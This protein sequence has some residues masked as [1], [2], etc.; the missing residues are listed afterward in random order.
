LADGSTWDIIRVFLASPGDLLRE[1]QEAKQV[2]ARLNAA[3]AEAGRFHCH[4][5]YWERMGPSSER[6]QEAINPAVDRCD[7]F[8]GL[9]GERWGHPTPEYT[10][11][12]EEEYRRASKRRDETGSPEIWLY[13]KQLGKGRVSDPGEDLRRVLAFRQEVEQKHLYAEFRSAREF[14]D[15]LYDRLLTYL[16][17]RMAVRLEE[18][19]AETAT[20][21]PAPGHPEAPHGATG[22]EYP[23]QIMQLGEAVARWTQTDGPGDEDADEVSRLFLLSAGWFYGQRLA[24]VLGV[25]EANAFYEMRRD[26]ELTQ[27]EHTLLVRSLV[28]DEYGRIPGYYWVGDQSDE[29]FFD[30]LISFVD[31]DPVYGVRA[32]A[33]RLLSQAGHWPAASD[34][35][36]AA[37]RDGSARVRL[38]LAR[39]LGGT[40]QDDAL[41]LTEALLEDSNDQVREA[42][43]WARLQLLSRNDPETAVEEAVRL[44]VSDLGRAPAQVTDGIA[45]ARP[46][47][48]WKLLSSTHAGVRRFAADALAQHHE[49]SEAEAVFLSRDAD[50]WVAAHGLL[51]L[52]RDEARVSP[53]EYTGFLAKCD[54]W[55]RD[56]PRGLHGAPDDQVRLARAR[57]LSP[58][59]L[60]A[61]MDFH[62]VDGPYM[63]RALAVDHFDLISDR[64]R[65][66][67]AERFE[68]IQREAQQRIEEQVGSEAARTIEASW[69]RLVPFLQARFAAAALA[70][71]A[72]HGRNGDEQ[73]AREWLAAHEGWRYQDLVAG[74]VAVLQRF[75]D[76]TDADLLVSVAEAEYGDLQASAASA[77]VSLAPGA[78]GAAAKLLLSQ[79]L[80]LQKAGLRAL[81]HAE[82]ADAKPLVRPLLSSDSL[83]LRDAATAFMI[84]VCSREELM[85]LQAEYTA[86]PAYYYSVVCLLDRALYAPGTLGEA[87]RTAIAHLLD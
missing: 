85:Q 23:G 65:T 72:Q 21:R 6:P 4:L 27:E 59:E 3:L 54:A 33:L 84:R 39:Y 20:G 53:E 31:S 63:Y 61:L 2:I 67:L 68:R 12:F 28:A 9:L 42:A 13:L 36:V 81:L 41:G 73:Y 11:G 48:L 16:Y 43:T 46:D 69:T 1:R 45:R 70:G 37:V 77:A 75:G 8:V 86:G 87:L 66:D 52:F 18:P 40:A 47:A 14:A 83:A 57:S 58:A 26:M 32:G 50:P 5:D 78:C 29:Q 74:A 24:G 30:L 44:E 62:D 60:F 22:G 82:P 19:T 38:A 79:P 10:S 55:R 25:H 64:I 17:G 80:P 7:I 35:L 34:A 15:G 76:D 49:L 56:H 51:R 71:L